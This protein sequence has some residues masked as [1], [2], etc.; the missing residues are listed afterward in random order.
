MPHVTALFLVTSKTLK[1]LIRVNPRHPF[2]SSG[3]MQRHVA[4]SVFICGHPWLKMFP[5]ND[6]M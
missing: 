6:G 3:G 5:P 1:I 4:L 2:S